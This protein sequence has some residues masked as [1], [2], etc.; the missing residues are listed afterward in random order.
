MK[1]IR[2]IAGKLPDISGVCLSFLCMIHCVVTP[3]A[4]TI[5][6]LYQHD[7]RFHQI[8]LGIG[9]VLSFLTLRNNANKKWR[10]LT[11]LCFITGWSLF[12]I[13]EYTH[14]H[15]M[16]LLRIMAGLVIAGGHVLSMRGKTY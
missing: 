15:D 9:L 6:V 12:I 1:T 2:A 14:G 7:H 3:L 11:I 10:L 13:V 4:G 16:L 5:I 8:I